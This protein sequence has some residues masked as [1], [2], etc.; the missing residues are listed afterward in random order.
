MN[1]S[2]ATDYFN[3]NV[4]TIPY[5]GKCGPKIGLPREHPEC[6]KTPSMW[7]I[8]IGP[9]TKPPDD[10]YRLESPHPFLQISK[11]DFLKLSH[12]VL[13]EPVNSAKPSLS[14]SRHSTTHSKGYSTSKPSI[15][16][17]LLP[18][19]M[20]YQQPKPPL[21][22]KETA[23]D[24]CFIPKSSITKPLA[25]FLDE[26]TVTN[27]PY[28][29]RFLNK[30]GF[31]EALVF[32]AGHCAS[33]KAAPHHLVHVYVWGKEHREDPVPHHAI[34]HLDSHDYP[35]T[36]ERAQL[37]AVIAALRSPE[38]WKLERYYKVVFAFSGD[39]MLRNVARVDLREQV[40]EDKLKVANEDWHTENNL[41]LRSALVDELEKMDDIRLR[42]RFWQVDSK[43]N[44]AEK[45][46]EAGS[47]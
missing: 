26:V 38:E 30:D 41:D 33:T 35:Y 15:T 3:R 12:Q 40:E 29:A 23:K 24:R 42:V 2:A 39:Y 7:E 19:K 31:K 6:V 32:V 27:P 16:I 8:L 44:E 18:I 22:H 47:I 5:P 11:Q 20:S 37:H 14:L 1:H 13:D 43:Y 46:I 17:T 28:V 10:K 21:N 9:S 4:K 25:L 34:K 36:A 45:L